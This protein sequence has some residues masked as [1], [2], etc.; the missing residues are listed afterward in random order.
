MEKF[1]LTL[2]W[3][4]VVLEIGLDGFVLLVEEGEVGYEVLDNVHC[5][6]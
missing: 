6:L 4:V 3:R 5:D 2:L 1:N